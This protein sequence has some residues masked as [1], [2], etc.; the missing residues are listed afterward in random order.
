LYV[1]AEGAQWR[2]TIDEYGELERRY[3]ENRSWLNRREDLRK[4]IESHYANEAADESFSA[5]GNVWQLVVGPRANKRTIVAMP[6]LFNRLGPKEFLGYCTFPLTTLDRLAVDTAGIVQEKRTGN[7][8]IAA[9]PLESPKQPRVRKKT[10]T[11][12]ES[13]S[14]VETSVPI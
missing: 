6:K 13:E 4:K 14:N 10:S 11:R 7:R 9:V 5:A 8:T 2:S 3:V 12:K 1:P